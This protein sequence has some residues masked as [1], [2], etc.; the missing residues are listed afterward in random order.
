MPIQLRRIQRLLFAM[1]G[2]LGLA[3]AA[4]AA[5]LWRQIDAAPTPLAALT[6]A[7]GGAAADPARASRWQQSIATLHAEAG[8]PRR[9]LEV[10]PF[11]PG[12]H[13]NGFATESVS[14][15]QGLRCEAALPALRAAAREH[16]FVFINEAHHVPQTRVLTHA[17]L[18]ALRAEGY[19]HFAVEA[20]HET[21]ADYLRR[22]YPS[23]RSGS[24]LAEPL[25]AELLREAVR[26]GY[27]LVPYEHMG[28]GDAEAREAAQAQQLWERSIGRDPRAKVLVHA[29]YAHVDRSGERLF[30]IQPLAQRIEARL[31]AAVLSVD[32][33]DLRSDPAGREHPMYRPLLAHSGASTPQVCRLD[34]KLW[35]LAPARNDVS[36]LLPDHGAEEKGPWF[37]LDGQRVPVAAA[38]LCAQRLPCQIEARAVSEG[39]DAVPADRCVQRDGRACTLYLAPGRYRLSGS[40]AT[41]QTLGSTGISVAA[42][43]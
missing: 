25:F 19:T 21:E 5:D 1:L 30:K 34:G 18:A 32:Q 3:S 11:G 42:G 12:G 6:L 14:V 39:A 22:G 13:R 37:S 35:A 38:P 24:Y 17:L 20:L 28:E 31:G 23:K 43:R 9:A 2:A 29:G 10:F 27:R 16:R 4:P 36:V 8:E 33:V 26:L 41:G 40:D 7:E 15:P